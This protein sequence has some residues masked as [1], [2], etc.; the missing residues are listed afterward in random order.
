MPCY[1][2]E[3]R[4]TDP[5]KHEAPW[6]RGVVG[7]EQILICPSCQ[8]QDPAWASQLERCPRCG[9]TRLSMQLGSIS[10]RSCGYLG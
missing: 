5:S 4:Q 7:A 6:G 8:E 10:C 2:C 9:S 1:R 3:R